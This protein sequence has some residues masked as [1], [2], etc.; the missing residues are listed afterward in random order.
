M[1]KMKQVAATSDR[2][3]EAM[4]KEHK[5]QI[6]LANETGINKGSISRYLAGEYEPKQ[7]AIYKLAKA[8]NVDEMWLWGYDVPMERKKRLADESDAL[9]ERIKNDPDLMDAIRKYYKLNEVGKSMVLAYIQGQYDKL[10]EDTV[11]EM[12][13][14]CV[15]PDDAASNQ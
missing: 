6:E 10:N 15:A 8:L 4:D 11:E 12:L 2:I 7:M 14:K 3:R 1:S 13:E 5:K 9:Y